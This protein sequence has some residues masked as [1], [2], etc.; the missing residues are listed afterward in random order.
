MKHIFGA[1]LIFLLFSLI[2]V[3]CNNNNNNNN[4]IDVN[5]LIQQFEIKTDDIENGFHKIFEHF[6]SSGK[7]IGLSINDK[8]NENEMESE[9]YKALS[10]IVEE[11]ED[12]IQRGSYDV[13]YQKLKMNKEK[14]IELKHSPLLYHLAECYLY[15]E[16]TER[17]EKEAF[18]I[19]MQ[20]AK[21]GCAKSQ[22]EI[23]FLYSTGRGV[24][25]DLGL[26]LLFYS[27][28]ASAGDIQ[29][30]MSLGFKYKEGL[31]VEKNCG[32]AL[33]YYKYVSSIVIKKIEEEMI[34]E[35]IKLKR[36]AKD[37]RNL[38]S[39]DQEIDEDN[40]E[41]LQLYIYNANNG[42]TKSQIAIGNLFLKGSNK[43]KRDFTKA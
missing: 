12:L 29:A 32:K 41:L 5:N 22:R 20:G 43:I 37:V 10:L 26:S 42:D 8:Q 25:R 38:V 34:E 17:D 40:D 21:F 2:L 19:L 39:Q 6:K 4:N 35:K 31:G 13:A 28:A 1:S 7:E 15:G 30:I 24:E 18:E 33:Y 27:F 14:A 36:I 9:E 23:G 3:V 11:S 16:G